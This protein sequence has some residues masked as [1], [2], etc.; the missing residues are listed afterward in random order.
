MLDLSAAFDTIDHGT[1]I[2]RL[3][4][5]FGIAGKPLEWIKSYL[6]NRTQSVSING[7]L[8]KPVQ[9]DFSVPQGSVLGPK[10]YTLYTQPL[11]QICRDHG[12]LYHF[13][14]DDSQLYLSFV[15]LSEIYREETIRRIEICLCEITNWM[16]SNMLKLNADKTE[17]ILFSSV[18]NLQHISDVSISVGDS[19]IKPSKSVRN[20]GAVFDSSMSMEEHVNSVCKSCYTQLRYIGRIRKYLSVESTK[21]LVNSLVISRLDYC[22]SLLYGISQSSMNKMQIVQNTAARIITR[23]SR[24]EH[25]TPVLIDLHWLPVAYRIKFKILTLTYKAL[26]GNSPQYIQDLLTVYKP[27]R[28]L[29]SE[30]Q[31]L[32]LEVPR[33]KTVSFGQRCFQAAA[34]KLWNDLPSGVRDSK[35]LYAF[36]RSLKTHFFIKAYE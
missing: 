1:L 35:S 36:K 29:R 13:Y 16:N 20:L 8:S 10:F 21:Q 9:L 25:I 18:N 30:T 31:S 17:V 2:D 15:P 23:T 28:S 4:S 19:K 5:Q 7:I 12:L 14:A 34:P 6:D 33:T 3:E 24:R 26:E 27:R 22:N 32:T 11:G